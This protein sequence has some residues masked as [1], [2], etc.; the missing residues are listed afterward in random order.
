MSGSVRPLNRRRSWLWRSATAIALLLQCWVAAAPLTEARGIGA[1]AHIE[2]SGTASHFAHNEATC[3]AC[4]LLAL[5]AVLPSGFAAERAGIMPALIARPERSA[6][7]ALP[8]YFSNQT[9]A[10]PSDR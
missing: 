4:I 2:A 3:A 1:S 7:P 10:P 6:P 5:R 9:R 8:T